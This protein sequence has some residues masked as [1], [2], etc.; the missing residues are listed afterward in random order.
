MAALREH[1]ELGLRGPFLRPAA[2]LTYGQTF[3]RLEEVDSAIAYYDAFLHPILVA[4]DNF[5][6]S[7]LP[8]V[9]RRLAELEEWRGNLEA[10]A[11]HYQRFLE[12]WSD[13]DPELRGQVDAAQRALTRLTSEG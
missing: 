3:E 1:V 7:Y 2:D 6:R 5:P 9:L 4:E 12:L 10:A 8:V 13:A 11:R